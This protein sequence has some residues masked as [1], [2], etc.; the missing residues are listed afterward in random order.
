MEL[1][2][3]SESAELMELISGINWQYKQ[4]VD[5]RL[6]PKGLPIEQYRILESL[7]RKDGQSMRELADDVFVDSASL[8]KIIDRMVG[9]ADVYRAPE[10][11]DRRK[12]LIF[13][14]VKGHRTLAELREALKGSRSGL[15]DRLGPDQVSQL[16]ALL[17][18]ML[19]DGDR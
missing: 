8:T 18:S 3:D 7:Q 11:T 13:I 4:A 15:V 16:R 9:T 14:S 17:Q 2:S 1:L 10:P 19:K 5:L 12:V 6:K